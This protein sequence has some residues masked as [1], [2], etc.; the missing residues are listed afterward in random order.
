MIE[1]YTGMAR[2]GSMHCCCGMGQFRRVRFRA[3]LVELSH[4]LF[5]LG[6]GE[7]ASGVVQAWLGAV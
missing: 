1:H 5:S 2:S 3:V 7:A 4:V 6:V